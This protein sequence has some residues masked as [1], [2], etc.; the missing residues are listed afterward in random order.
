MT[1]TP[2]ADE[3]LYRHFI[4]DTGSL[5]TLVVVSILKWVNNAIQSGLDPNRGLRVQQLESVIS[6]RLKERGSKFAIAELGLSEHSPSDIEDAKERI[7]SRYLKAFWSDHRI[8]EKE[9]RDLEWFRIKLEIEP[10]RAAELHRNFARDS[11]AVVLAEAMEDGV[12][13][14]DERQKLEHI[15]TQLGMSVQE[16]ARHFFRRESEQFLRGL[17][18]SAVEDGGLSPSAWTNLLHAASVLGIDS[19]ELTKAIQPQA[20]AFVEHVLADAKQDNSISADEEKHLVW[21]GRNLHIP[22]KHLRY[23]ENEI[24][25]LKRLEAISKGILPSLER[26]SGIEVVSGEIVHFAAH[27]TLHIV[28]HLKSGPVTSAHPG[29]L[30]ITNLRTLF[31]SDAKSFYFRHSSL[32]GHSGTS[33]LI[34]LRVHGKPEMSFYF[35]PPQEFVYPIL[36]TAVGLANQTKITI[37]TSRQSR[38]ISRDVRQI[39]WQRYGGRCADCNALEYL[40]FDHIVPVAKGGSNSEAN[41]QLLCRRC[42]LRKSDRI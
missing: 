34:D 18:L 38:H 36:E 23:V 17:F 27:C 42:N 35:N 3:I 16:Y 8:S 22:E 12:I 9:A 41:V 1:K 4:S 32:I 7:F 5:P 20:I 11:F 33:R 15:A 37:D 40:E 14:D 24:E 26:P 31:S 2:E 28:R 39:V 29:L 10:K 13:D 30:C 25:L 19:A 21:L 6:R